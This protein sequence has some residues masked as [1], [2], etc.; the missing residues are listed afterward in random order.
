MSRSKELFQEMK[1]E[2][3]YRQAKEYQQEKDDFLYETEVNAK[4]I[5][6]NIT[7]VSVNKIQMNL[8]NKEQPIIIAE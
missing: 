7:I 2:E 8:E 5:E 3:Y 1:D 4:R 6:S